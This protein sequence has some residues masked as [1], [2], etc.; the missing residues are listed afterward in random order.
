MQEIIIQA[1]TVEEAVENGCS[2]L[3]VNR[4]SV[5]YEVLEMPQKKLFGTSPAKVA[6]RTLAEDD[7][8]KPQP[9][10]PKMEQPARKTEKRQEPRPPRHREAAPASDDEEMEFDEYM[11]AASASETEIE[12]KDIPVPGAAALAYLREV[13]QQ[14]GAEKLT[15]RFYRTENGVKFAI[16]GEDSALIIGRRG[17]TMESLQYLC[18]LVSS[19]TGGE[20]CKVIIDAANYRSKREKALQNLASKEAAKVKKTSF[21]Q[22]LE[23]M[24]PYERRIVHSAI[25][26]IDG[27]KS[28]SVGNEP[29]RRVVLSLISGGRTSRN[30]RK[31]DKPGN[32]GKK[33]RD[34]RN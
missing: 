4:D 11:E 14:M 31:G 32:S 5:T 34:N 6:I 33:D 21:R 3:G 30:S 15:Y 1:A 29:H 25:Q 28:E 10:K 20:Y 12:E 2:Q 16:D 9:E 13:A 22:V 8:L 23:P 17:E 24:N 26:K 18:M 19:R 7:E 27:V